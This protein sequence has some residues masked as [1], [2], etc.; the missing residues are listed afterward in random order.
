MCVNEIPQTCTG[1]N[2]YVE[3]VGLFSDVLCITE[4][5]LRT[6]AHAVLCYIGNINL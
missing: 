5:Y 1:G 2:S 6:S 3:I 4:R